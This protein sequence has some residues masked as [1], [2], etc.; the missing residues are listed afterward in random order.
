MIASDR[1]YAGLNVIFLGENPNCQA[2]IVE[3]CTHRATEVHHKRGRGIYKLVVKTWL[4]VCRGCHNYIG[5]NHQKAVD[6]GF[7][8]SRLDQYGDE[9]NID[10]SLN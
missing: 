10:S 8:E 7:C 6:A 5:D 9:L 4:A 3:V 1:I 2:R